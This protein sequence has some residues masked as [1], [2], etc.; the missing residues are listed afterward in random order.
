MLPTWP[1]RK[2]QPARRIGIGINTALIG[3]IRHSS[4]NQG[5]GPLLSRYAMLHFR[6]RYLAK[7]LEKNACSSFSFGEESFCFCRMSARNF[8]EYLPRYA[9]LRKTQWA[10]WDYQLLA[11]TT[12]SHYGHFSCT[13]GLVIISGFSSKLSFVAIRACRCWDSFGCD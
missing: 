1:S 11:Q 12:T 2:E 6:V 13:R 5:T 9:G 3:L 4:R 10:F 8:P 7:E